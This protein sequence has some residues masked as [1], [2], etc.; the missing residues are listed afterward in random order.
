MASTYALKD[1]KNTYFEYKVLEKI[2]GQPTM[3]NLLT[4]FRQ[5]KRNAQCV[6]CALGGEQL[7]YLGL[8]L[9]Q[10]AYKKS[11]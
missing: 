3:D 8:I 4:L 2:H 7:G 6:T 10:E 5:L 1:Y 11:P 9:S